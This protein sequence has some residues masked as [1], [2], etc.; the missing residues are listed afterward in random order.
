MAF[1]G[2]G[3]G[4]SERLMKRDYGKAFAAAS[5]NPAASLQK[6]GQVVRYLGSDQALVR[7]RHGMMLETST[8]PLRTSHGGGSER[9]VDLA[10]VRRGS[11]YMPANPLIPVTIAGDSPAGIVVGSDGLGLTMVGAPSVGIADGNGVFFPDVGIDTDGLAAPTIGGVE[12]F[13]LLRSRLSAQQIRY[14]VSLPSGTSL[15]ARGGGAI[16]SRGS[17]TIARI[18]APSARDAQGASVPV[19]MRVSGN[20]LVVSVVPDSRELAYPVLV[21]PELIVITGEE[22]NWTFEE[23]PTANFRATGPADLENT[24]EEYPYPNGV[25][26]AKHPGEEYFHFAEA[27]WRWRAPVPSGRSSVYTVDF[28]HIAYSAAVRIIGEH[29]F[30]VQ[31]SI[32]VGCLGG[33]QEGNFTPNGEE[34]EE[35]LPVPPS[36]A[37]MRI[38][39]CSDGEPLEVSDSLDVGQ[40]ILPYEDMYERGPRVD[41]HASLSIGAILVG[42][43]L[44]GEEEAFGPTSPAEPYQARCELGQQVNCA[45]GNETVQQSDLKIGGR[46]PLT[47][48]RTYNS[49]LALQAPPEEGIR[50][51]RRAS[52]GKSNAHA[53]LAS[54]KAGAISPAFDLAEAEANPFGIGWTSSYS[55]HLEVREGL[56]HIGLACVYQSNGSTVQ[57]Y[58]VGSEGWK[59]ENPGAQSQLEASSGGYTYTMPD[60]T[61]LVFNEGGVLTEELDRN[62]NATKLTHGTGGRLETI[63]DSSGHKITLSYDSEGQ[64]ASATDSMG[65]TVKY[66]YDNGDLVGVTEPGESSVT[67]SFGYNREHELTSEETAAGTVT[68]EYG[69]GK[70]TKQTVGESS[71]KWR[72]EGSETEVTEPNG[73]VTS[74]NFNVAGLPTSIT[75]AAGTTSAAVTSYEY[76][77]A[78]EPTTIIDPEGHKTKYGYD[79]EGNRTSETNADGDERKWTYDGKH[80]V[81]SET[82]PDG[83]TTTIIRNS[84]GDPEAIERPGPGGSTQTT[85]YKYDA[86]GDVESMTDPLGHEWK[87]EY[88]GNGD[89]IAEVDPE[90][91]KRTW[92]YNEDSQETSTVSPRGNVSGG[93]PAEYR[94][95]IER[96]AQGRAVKVIAPAA[97]EPAKPMDRTPATIS[98]APQEAQTLTAATGV[99]EGAPSLSY[100]YQ[101]E[102]CNASGGSCAS[103]SGA[104]SAS[105][106][107]GPG[108][109]GDALRVV[110]TA[111]NS[112]GSEASTSGATPVVV[113]ALVWGNAFGSETLHHPDGDA[114]DAHGRVWVTSSSG[115]PW[116]QVFSAEGEQ[117]DTY[118]ATGTGKGDF[119]DPDGIAINTSTGAVYVSDGSN[120]WIQEYTEAGVAGKEIGK[121]GSAAG[122]FEKPVAVALDASGDLWVADYTGQRIDEFNKEGT[123]LKAFGWGVN[124]GGSKLEVC[125]TSCKAGK[126]GTGEGELDDPSGVEYAGG[127][128]HVV[129]SGADRL[130]KFTTAGEYV[131]D[132]AGEGSG[133]GELSHPANET[134]EVEGNSY[135]ADAGNNRVEKFGPYG[136]FIETFGSSGSGQGQFK[137]TGDVAITP[138][139]GELFV[140]DP[141]N[142]RVEK[143]DSTTPPAFTATIGA[144]DFSHAGG[145]AIDAKGRVWVTNA[146]GNPAI[147]VFSASGT[148]EATYGEHGSEKGEYVEPDGIA[149]NQSTGNVYVADGAAG[150]VDELSEKGVIVDE[151]GS[152]GIGA[153][154]MADPVAVA[155]DP[156]GDIWVADHT[157][158]RIEEFNKEGTFLKAVGWG[159]KEGAAKLEACTTSC[160]EG[161]AGSGEGQFNDLTGIVYTDGYLHIVDAGNDRLEKFSTSGEYAG[162]AAGAGSGNGQLSHPEGIAAGPGGNEY[163]ADAGNDRIE[164][165]NPYGTF[166]AA[167][168]TA[169][170]GGG[171]FNEP[172]GLA[173]GLSEEIYVADGENSRLSKWLPAG[174]PVDTAP[175]TISGELLAG[176]TLSAST[177]TWSAI[178]AAGYS[179]QWQDCSA[180][181]GSCSNVSGAT[182]ETY[183]LASSDEGHTLKV[184]VTA[185]NSVGSASS[186]SPPTPFFAAAPTTAYH[187]DAGGNLESVTDPDGATTSFTYNADD[188]LTKVK[189]PN[190]TVTET[191]YD[192]MGQVTSQTNGD[193]HTTEY[194]R[195]LLEE[196]EEEVNPL[197][198]KTLKEYNTAG[199]LVK[200]TD[201]KG[202]TTSYTYDPANRLTE[203]SYSSG[204]PSTIT[205]EYN[206]DGDRT[207]MTDGTGTTKYEYDQLDR[208]TESENAHK[209]VVKYE[210]NLADEPTK[211]TYPNGK[212]VARTYDKDDRLE[213][214]T[215]WLEHTTSFA[216]N[217]D[218]ELTTTTFPA[219]SKDEDKYAYSRDDEVNEI[220][221]LKS[222]ETLAAVGY[223]RDSNGQITSTVSKGLPGEEAS[224]YHYDESG[225]LTKAASTSYE[226][227]AANDP[228]KQGTSEYTYN[229]GGELE[230]ST[231]ATYSYDELGERTKTT[232][233]T[234]PATT[235][236]YDQAGDLTS[237]ER[238]KE[239]ESPEIK[240]T[241]AYNGEGLRVS[242]TINGTTAYMAWD[243]AEE[244]P[245]LLNDA[246]NSYIYGPNGLP[247]EQ[248]NNST[249]AV[250]YL[251]HD[252]AG[253]TRLLTGST[254]TVTG[255]CTYSAYGTPACEGTAT[256]PLGYDG[257]Y[258]SSDT[259]LIYMRARIYDPVTAQFLTRDPWVSITGEPYSYAED[260][261]INKADPSGRCG[262][263]CWVG[264]GLGVASI[265]TG[266][267]AVLAGTEV[268][269]AALATTSA[270]AGAG[271]TIADTKECFGGS[272]ISCVGVGVGVVATAGASGFIFGATG[273]VVAG[274]TAIGIT[275]GGIGLLS[276]VAGAIVPGSASASPYSA[277]G[278]GT[279]E[280]NNSSATDVCG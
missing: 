190:G 213:K 61:K 279:T 224:E 113:A 151:I 21:D 4:Q 19:T 277:T 92:G 251:H 166:I 201:P 6:M 43:S 208:L 126:A 75:H 78:G 175:P 7:T 73:A 36:E 10:L 197:G 87:Y 34:F 48:A 231:G 177:G 275:S 51:E 140:T 63:S 131:G 77:D 13:T 18:P 85:R 162:Q 145:A 111:S 205:Y 270:A 266:I 135:V 193:K 80:D 152:K 170:S 54:G 142:S 191:G 260:D 264:I 183:T 45:T 79:S 14:R 127:Y 38:G 243:T 3:V 245:L 236:G 101:W 65:H 187:Y 106:L 109:V 107:L 105:Y 64:V 28:E 194:K 31:W 169:G 254:G 234:G 176:Q 115:A 192:A 147:E 32:G 168:G 114:I 149:I 207:K 273:D 8:V 139:L 235:Y 250:E 164:E 167:F 248:I 144:G 41:V 280:V 146:K 196:V 199:E 103:V 62:G 9:A 108:D 186:T 156:A 23:E 154:Q 200:V 157:G 120:D 58:R 93:S 161:K 271:A 76:N 134:T 228:T 118:G 225:R 17:S 57:F 81:V 227:D 263:I 44:A 123:F 242:Q 165:F 226:Y 211:I 173:V 25:K 182:S 160:K 2:L 216:Y 185:T 141:G 59:P 69:S 110:V 214:V 94:T 172:T 90:G 124:K 198:K 27:W 223:G 233:T 39:K 104:T 257:Q 171:Q 47:F 95:T 159:V 246:T 136:G 70:V 272:N 22:S 125:T 74:E 133:N 86:D 42:E 50:D 83:E 219:E 116:L 232:P 267:G 258:T 274:A 121:K 238:P 240:D 215:D 40:L 150:R 122:D 256:T 189:E 217:P 117:L 210:Y 12:M 252:Q 155:L 195:N 82:S 15:L 203:V 265:A 16:V 202:R 209:E 71:R 249:G 158:Q 268:V 237:V 181:G 180:T 102:R 26:E 35:G 230:K 5:A 119:E 148:R 1:H 46:D 218:S 96:D 97:G 222:T 276:D 37:G 247:V 130:Q 143:W 84:A 55:A 53:T 241:Y 11:A 66:E 68:N 244:L 24:R 129:D 30:G 132:A 91:N 89:R 184:I 221:M 261:P 229:G 100:G 137:E 99:W 179:Y 204:S 153:G 269:T 278:G 138:T 20:E 52:G 262:V 112:S 220:T 33:W 98:G 174:T 206:K 188:E 128:I 29:T 88:D 72:Y 67:D 255:K 212:A 60:Q 239:G 253:S 49:Q 163:V 178:P 56:E 259:G